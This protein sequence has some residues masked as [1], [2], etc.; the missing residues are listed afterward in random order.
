MNS[1]N[2][3][4]CESENVNLDDYLH[5][6]KYVRENMDHPEW[7]GT[8]S[9]EEIEDILTKGGKI[10]L[11][12]DNNTLVC[13]MFYIPANNKS[14]LKH[15]ITSDEKVTA[16]L[17]PIM[18]SPEYIGHGYQNQMMNLF[19]NYCRTLNQKYIFTKV[20]KDNIYSINNV[21]KNDYRVVDEY[22]S[23]RGINLAFLKEIK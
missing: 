2:N 1:I 21:L 18:V 22:E 14:L 12:Y 8:F 9:K 3:F 7:L 5:L 17:G 19:E 13:S 16:S 10:W 20:C 23:E 6:Y 11:Y 15:N 4:R